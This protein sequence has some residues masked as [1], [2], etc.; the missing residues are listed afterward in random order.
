VSRQRTLLAVALVTVLAACSP[1]AT[2][3]VASPTAGPTASPV[4]SASPASAASAT[5]TPAPSVDI[6]HPDTVRFA[7]DWTPN[8]D[9][10]GFYVAQAKGWYAAAG[11]DFKVLPYGNTAPETLMATGQADCGISFQDYLTF[12][13]ASGVRIK[14]VMAILQHAASVIAVLADSGITRP[15]QL[16]GKTYAGFGGA[17]EVP[18]LKAVI[19]AD[20][21]S[22]DFKVVQ[23]DST[24]Y[25][26]LYSHKADFTI[27]FTAWEGV[28]AAERGIKLR[29]FAF[30]DYGFPDF[31][32]VV[33]ACSDDWLTAHP[34]AAQR[35]V[36]ATVRGFQ[37]AATDPD[38]TAALL[39]AQNPGIFDANK[40]LPLDSARFLAQGGYYVD[41]TGHVGTQTLAQWT[42][43]SRFLFEQGLLTGPDGKPLTTAPDYGTL[44]T[45]EF[46]P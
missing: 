36:G 17:S 39:I 5:P 21:G 26:A 23:A 3:P 25:E 40:Q 10:T 43:Y 38:G 7:L 12:A 16:D 31:Y 8:T 30:A 18:M 45:N 4:A 41:A 42:G 35:F 6:A 44:F 1:S 24:A 22:G 34:A 37:T 29:T 9:H 2:S 33:L 15:R 20:G 46:L 13:V 28:E 32:Q 27:P 11:I 14:S 19:K